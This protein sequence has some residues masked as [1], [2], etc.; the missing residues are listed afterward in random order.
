M[1]KKSRLS[2]LLLALTMTLSLTAP[3]AAYRAGNLLPQVKPY[4]RPFADTQ[5]RWCA[6]AVQTV[7]ETGLMEGKSA[8]SFDPNGTLTCAQITVITARLHELL[9]G[10]DGKF[11]APGDGEAW[12]QPAADYLVDLWMQDTTGE[13]DL[14]GD[15]DFLE[16][17]A[18]TPCNRYDFVW[19]LSAVLP[20]SALTPINA[21][22]ALPD[23]GDEDVLAFYNAGIL[24]GTDS[25]GTF[26]G[27]DSL[28]R[29][30]A[31]AML[32]RIVDPSQ[33]VRFTP[34]E[35]CFTRELLALEPE[36]TVLTID[37][38]DVSAE[39]YAYTVS[40]NIQSQM[41]AA[42][43][44][45]YDVYAQYLDEYFDDEV[46]YEYDDFAAYLLEKYGIDVEQE[47]AVQW[48]KPDEGGMS[49]A[50][51][52]TEDTL[53]A[54]TEVAMLFTHASAYPLTAAQKA[55]IAAGVAEDRADYYGFTEEFIIA[56]RTSEA[57]L[58]NAGKKYA[59]SRSQLSGY[60]ADNGCFYGRCIS[61]GY[62]TEDSEDGWYGRTEAEA[63][64]LALTVRREAIAYL[65][66]DDYFG[67][68]GWKYDDGYHDAYEE[69]DLLS[70]D[71]LSQADQTALRNLP[72]GSLSNPIN[73]K[74]W[75][76]DYGTVNLY[77]KDDPAESEDFISSLGSVAVE[78]Q[79]SQW[80]EKA[81]VTATAAY[82]GLR[83]PDIAARV[84]AL[85][86]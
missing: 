81:N 24:T 14:L 44:K 23:C 32:A 78:V 18:N 29:G 55:D 22:Q 56:G 30:Q 43:F 74:A 42:S 21:I 3:A 52:V 6:D 35:F 73:E 15:L 51:K 31:A 49:P 16:D 64:Q 80:A 7:Y 17:T 48:D 70:V 39:L 38:Y 4:E 72:V 20:D 59:P 77:L 25:L 12:Y 60:L 83:I 26:H 11:D 62:D 82:D 85:S 41:L 67:Y 19:L 45:Y 57:L 86:A 50:Q 46:F 61:I 58:E 68:L 5:G 47:F 2:A 53:D 36:T 33:R 13:Y 37:G 71:S 66:D 84:Q 76:D 34:E 9:N 69:P 63:R 10:G 8:Q 75:A 79:L 65:R 1:M 54:L 40:G 27:F 28:T